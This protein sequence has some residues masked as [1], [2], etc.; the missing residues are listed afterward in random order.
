MKRSNFRRVF[1]IAATAFLATTVQIH[2]P[3]EPT[4][5]NVSFKPTAAAVDRDWRGDNSFQVA[6]SHSSTGQLYAKRS[7]GRSGGGSFQRSSPPRQSSP[8]RQSNPPSN[9][10]RYDG[11]GPVVVPVPV[12]PGYNSAP[13]SGGY[14]NQGSQTQA[15]DDGSWIVGLIV[16]IVVAILLFLVIFY[17]LKALRRLM[18]GGKRGDREVYNDKVTV[19][20]IQ[21]ALLAEARAIQAELTNLSLQ[22]D[23]DTEWGLLQLLQESAL[24][25]L[26]TPEN[27]SHVLASSQ[28]VKSRKQA[29]AV[30]SRLSIDERTK[31][32]TETLANVDGRIRQ[33]QDYTPDLDKDPASYIVVT[34]LVGTTYDKPLFAEIRTAEALKTVLE[35][36][37]AIPAEHLLVFE[38]I[39]TPQAESDSLTY[40][41]LLMQYTEM[42]Q[43]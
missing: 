20:K 28:R 42:V 18:A 26:R 4:K 10:R 38:L 32:T 16:L 1:A 3:S 40:E 29:E 36:L 37:A 17:I 15:S 23:T 31:Y 7:G 2:L 33:Q 35:K 11:G 43:I 6:S 8:S 12:G 30:F 14:S 25:L 22:V 34:L 19:S 41:E 21:V 39:W 27:W 9:Q 13:Y 24:A 5:L